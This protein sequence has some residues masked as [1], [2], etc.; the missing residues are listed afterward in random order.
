MNIFRYLLGLGGGVVV[1]EEVEIEKGFLLNFFEKVFFL[2]II[3][4]QLSIFLWGASLSLSHLG[5]RCEI[6]L[7]ICRAIFS[8]LAFAVCVTSA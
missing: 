8:F 2:K 7:H 1:E 6:I 3:K 4:G 5:C